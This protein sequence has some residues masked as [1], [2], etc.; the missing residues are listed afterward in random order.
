MPWRGSRSNLKNGHNEEVRPINWA[1][2]PQSYIQ[3]TL[4]WDEFPNGRWG[5]GRSPAFGELSN[6]HFFKPVGSKADCL[7]MWGDSPIILTDIYEI[8]AKYVEGK[9]PVLPWCESALQLE[10]NLISQELA[11]INRYGF[12]TINSQPAVNGEK[13]DH[14]IVG[15]GGVGGRVYQKAYVEFF[16]S[17]KILQELLKVVNLRSNL[18]LFAVNQSKSSIISSEDKHVTAVTWGVFPN[19]EIIQPTVFDPDVFLIWSEEAFSLWLK[20]WASLYD[21]ETDS[22]GLLYEVNVIYLFLLEND[23]CLIDRFMIHSIWLQ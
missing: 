9:I 10:T 8:F 14:P 15:W 16:V 22:A 5:D 21:D 23:N 12:L 6:Y 11:D 1:N 4:A 3:R 13:S 20:S 7:I 2:R 18:S 19:R 17:P